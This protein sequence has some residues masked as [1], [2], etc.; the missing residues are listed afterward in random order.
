MERDF[1]NLRD[2]DDRLRVLI[3]KGAELVGGAAGPAA[4]TVI[5]SL[6]A[7]PAGA[8]VGGSI[9]TAATMAVKAIGHDLSSRLLSPRE[10]ARV[11]GVFTLAAAEIVERSQKGESVRD[12]GFFDTGGSGRSDAEEVWEST[13]LKSQREAEEKKLPYMAHL[14]AN[15]AFD[16]EI[17]AAMA[18]QM[19]KAA[20]SMTYR[21]LCILQ[22]SATKERF[23]LRKRSYEGQDSFPKDSYQLI[24]EYYDLYSRG[25]INFGD[26]LA[27]TLV[28]VNPG[29]AT[30]QALGVDI[31]YQMRLYLIPDGELAPIAAHLR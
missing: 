19:T 27:A 15:L 16:T 22:L 7:G 18:H 30:P 12:D 29:A 13:L 6:L 2:R 24:Y 8:A 31:Y 11:G 20:E 28:D 21:Q 5:G 1:D 3:N 23:N 17:S 26:T 9:G 10:Q 14:L 25:L 4:G